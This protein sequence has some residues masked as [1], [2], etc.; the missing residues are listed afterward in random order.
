M[1]TSSLLSPPMLS[2]NHFN[3]A[4][5]LTYV[6]KLPVNSMLLNSNDQLS[7]IIL[8]ELSEAFFSNGLLSW[9]IFFSLLLGCHFLGYM[10]EDHGFLLVVSWRACSGAGRPPRIP[11]HM[12]ISNMAAYFIKTIRR[13]SDLRESPATFTLCLF[14][15]LSQTH[16]MISL[17]INSKEIDFGS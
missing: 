11:C 9:N 6:L 14:I 8:H 15:W 13:I 3:Q 4:F 2:W 5:V 16:Q 10:I 7:V 17:L 12:S 1:V